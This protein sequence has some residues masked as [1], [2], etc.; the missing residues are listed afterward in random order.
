LR[1]VTVWRAASRL[2]QVTVEG[3]APFNNPRMPSGE[4]ADEEGEPGA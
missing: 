2:V 3:S 1:T 4:S